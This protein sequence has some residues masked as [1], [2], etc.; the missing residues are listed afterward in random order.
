[1]TDSEATE[2]SLAPSLLTLAY[3]MFNLPE[4]ESQVLW[5]CTMPVLYEKRPGVH[6][7][8]RPEKGLLSNVR[9]RPL[10]TNWTL[11]LTPSTD[12]GGLRNWRT[13]WRD[14]KTRSM[15]GPQAPTL[16]MATTASPTLDDR[17]VLTLHWSK[18]QVMTSD[19]IL[20]LHLLLSKASRPMS[21][22][23]WLRSRQVQVRRDKESVISPIGAHI[24]TMFCSHPGRLCVELKSHFRVPSSAAHR[25]CTGN[26]PYRPA[27]RPHCSDVSLGS[28]TDRVGIPAGSTRII[29]PSR[30]PA[31]SQAAGG[32][33]VLLQPG[34]V[35]L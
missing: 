12:I 3:Q 21:M 13:G 22:L 5:Y 10:F 2:A 28:S 9:R 11:P 24:L 18:R 7:S 31:M 34:P 17:P 4:E 30:L 16:A 1:M 15:Q 35:S 8:R 26:R 25:R 6:D 14:T 32:I 29:R 19:G 27:P 23:R 33:H 20:Q